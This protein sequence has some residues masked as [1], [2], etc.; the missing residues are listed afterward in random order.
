MTQLNLYIITLNNNGSYILS[1]ISCIDMGREA[2]D[3]DNEMLLH[4]GPNNFNKSVE[5]EPTITQLYRSSGNILTLHNQNVCHI[6]PNHHCDG[7]FSNY[8]SQSYAQKD[9]L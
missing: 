7:Q 1:Q 2:S 6:V 4:Q 9:L 8:W 3:N 5:G